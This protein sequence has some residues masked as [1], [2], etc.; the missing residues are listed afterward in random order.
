MIQYYEFGRIYDDGTCSKCSR[1]CVNCLV[2]GLSSSDYYKCNGCRVGYIQDTVDASK[3]HKC[4]LKCKTC[5]PD[6][7][8]CIECAEGREWRDG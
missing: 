6:K 4:N 7:D 5:G 1:A 2:R 3:C 8:T